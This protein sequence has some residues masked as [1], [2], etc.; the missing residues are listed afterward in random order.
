MCF[1]RFRRHKLAYYTCFN[2]ELRVGVRSRVKVAEERGVMLGRRGAEG[3]YVCCYIRSVA[4]G[5]LHIDL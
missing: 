3:C 2:S 4:L 5:C 1:M